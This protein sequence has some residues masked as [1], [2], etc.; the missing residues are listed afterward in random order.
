MQGGIIPGVEKLRNQCRIEEKTDIED[1]LRT[2]ARREKKVID[3]VS[4]LVDCCGYLL[5]LFYIRWS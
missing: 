1:R 3:G 4:G 5:I 2:Q